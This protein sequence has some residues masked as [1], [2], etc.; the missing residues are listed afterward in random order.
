MTFT[1]SCKIA[2][3]A[4]LVLFGGASSA[5][6]AS[7][8]IFGH[9]IGQGVVVSAT[10][11]CSLATGTILFNQLALNTVSNVLIHKLRSVHYD[12]SGA[13][14]IEKVVFHKTGGTDLQP[15]GILTLTDEETGATATGTYSATY[16][17][18]DANSFGEDINWTY[19]NASGTCT[20]EHNEM[21]IR[22]SAD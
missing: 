14:Y 5:P 1:N 16:T 18:I 17:P 2:A 15:T 11:A 7:L 22:S 3:A 12:A 19:T 10:S 8:P 20:A 6:A 21:F 4:A 13:P 9:Y